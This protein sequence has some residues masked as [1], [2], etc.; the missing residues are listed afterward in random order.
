MDKREQRARG[1]AA[2]KAISASNRAAYSAAI[3]AHIESSVPYL[4]AKTILSYR[5]ANGEADLSGL[6]PSGKSIAYPVCLDGQRMCAC[7][8]AGGIF[9][10]GMYGIEAPDLARATILN[11]ADIDLVLVP[12]TA[13]DEQG[14]RLGMGG[15]YYD[16][17]LSACTRAVKMLVAFEAQKTRAV[18]HGALD[19]RMDYA[20]TEKQLR[21][22]KK[23]A[24]PLF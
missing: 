12:C 6:N 17:Y 9:V 22:F 7:V 24:K 19:V 23:P 8:P 3:I 5:A 10:R 20:V 4:C 16:R 2:R 11:P 21:C 13:F 14:G 15:G 18:C 1:I